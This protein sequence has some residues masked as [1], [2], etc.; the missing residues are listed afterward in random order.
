MQLELRLE[1]LTGRSILSD[2]INTSPKLWS[3]M[4][5]VIKSKL[6]MYI[7]ASISQMMCSKPRTIVLE[8]L[9]FC[10]K[11]RNCKEREKP[12]KR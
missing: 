9:W 5:K 3:W 10:V 1:I 6:V 8:L 12:L 7:T 4:V 11:I 2:T